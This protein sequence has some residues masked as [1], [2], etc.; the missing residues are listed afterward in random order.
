MIYLYI[1]PF[2]IDEVSEMASA[3]QVHE[4]GQV[5]PKGEV[6]PQK[7]SPGDRPAQDPGDGKLEVV[8]LHRKPRVRC[9]SA[10][11]GQV[12]GSPTDVITRETHQL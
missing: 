1:K 11:H 8:T 3:F 5:F 12:P 4:K 10:V 2:R 9:V 7:F 6:F